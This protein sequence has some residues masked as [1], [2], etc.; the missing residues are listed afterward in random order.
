M[1]SVIIPS[2][3]EIFL[4]KTIRDVLDKAEGETE[5]IPILDGYDVPRLEDPRVKYIHFPE[6]KGMRAGINAGLALSKGDYIMKSDA[7]CMFEQGFDKK[8]MI[9]CDDDWVVVPR[10][11]RLEA[12]SWTLENPHRVPFDYCYMDSPFRSERAMGNPNWFEKN[13]DPKF[14]D[15]LIDDNMIF[16]GSCWFTKK[17]HLERMEVFETEHYWG[18][19][20]E[21]QELCCK[22]WLSGGSVKVN[23]KVWYAHLRKGSRWGRMYHMNSRA[24]NEGHRYSADYWIN[25]RWPKQTRKFEW[26]IDKFWP[27]PSWKENWKE[28]KLENYA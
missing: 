22:T 12:E 4:D 24:I 10:R 26:I 23:K 20:Q 16:Q 21:P 27:V 2:L 28:D 19:E 3:N 14:K 15:I 25:N 7:H 1:L 17:K 5:V 13:K 11:M 18:W 6:R 8:L 9:D